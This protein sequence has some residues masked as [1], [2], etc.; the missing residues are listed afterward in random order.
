VPKTTTRGRIVAAGL[1]LVRGDGWRGL[2]VRGLAVQ[3]GIAP[4]EVYRHFP[5]KEAIVA[6]LRA[7]CTAAMARWLDHGDDLDTEDLCRGLLE[8]ARQR[9]WAYRILFDRVHLDDSDDPARDAFLARAEACVGSRARASHLWLAMHGYA[10][11][12]TRQLTDD[13]D[14]PREGLALDPG[15]LGAYVV[16]ITRGVGRG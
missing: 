8:F 3:C 9:P 6:A 13:V 10:T 15:F 14:A 5:N 1:E 12:L 4:A 7:E 16:A 2:T 11:V